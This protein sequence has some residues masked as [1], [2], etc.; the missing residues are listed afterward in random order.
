MIAAGGRMQNDRV[1]SE[2]ELTLPAKGKLGGLATIDEA[3]MPHIESRW[4]YDPSRTRSTLTAA[5]SPTRK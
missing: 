5:T 3:G 2:A 4:R 1:L